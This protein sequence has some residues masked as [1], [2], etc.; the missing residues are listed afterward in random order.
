MAFVMMISAAFLCAVITV[1]LGTTTGKRISS[2]ASAAL[3]T[4]SA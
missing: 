3:V 2:V 4:C 1:A